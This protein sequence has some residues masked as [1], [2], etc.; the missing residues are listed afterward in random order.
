ML[1]EQGLGR[2]QQPRAHLELAALAPG[3]RLGFPGDGMTGLG[4]SH[5]GQPTLKLQ[6]TARI[7]LNA[8]MLRGLPRSD[9][10]GG[11]TKREGVES[12][13]HFPPIRERLPMIVGVPR[14]TKTN[15]NRV[16]LV[17]A[18]CEAFVS[19][20]HSVCIEKGAGLGSGFPDDAYARWARSCCPRRPRSGARPR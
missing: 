13:V 11:R 9:S 4:S 1:V 3:G 18:G 14:E 6:S 17:P 7:Y 16:A 12:G 10:G 8:A 19:A 2:R 20:G 5:A 15:E